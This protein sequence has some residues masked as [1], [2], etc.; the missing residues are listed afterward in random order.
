MAKMSKAGKKILEGID[1]ALAYAKGE[2]DNAVT[3]HVPDTVDVKAIRG[4][5]KLSQQAFAARFG[6]STHAVRN[7]E[8]GV[9]H[10]EAATRAYLLVIKK[11]PEAVA[12]ALTE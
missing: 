3:I 8:Q 7:W 10:P 4:T 9:R 6:F 11:E 5:M 12:R 2:D 1:A